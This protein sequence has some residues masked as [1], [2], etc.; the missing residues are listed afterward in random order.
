MKTLNNFLV[1]GKNVLVRVDLNVPTNDAGIVTDQTKLQVIK[2]TVNELCSRKNK[3]FLLSHFGRPKGKFSKKYSLKFLKK[4][5]AEIL[6][7]EQIYFISSCYG[8]E[9]NRQ[10]LL[11]RPGDICLLEN[12]RFH[13]EEEKN[14]SSFSELLT[15]NFD[16]YVNEAFSASQKMILVFQSY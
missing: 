4:S 15:K 2:S 1:E 12:S 6:S 14:D 8:E 11:M 5:L 13:E 10:K 9:V 3:V 16:V 7:V